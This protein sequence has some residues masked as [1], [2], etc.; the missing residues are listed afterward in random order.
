MKEK[1]FPVLLPTKDASN[2][3]KSVNGLRYLDTPMTTV[4]GWAFI[5]P[6]HLYLTSNREIRE[7]DWYYVKEDN[8]ILQANFKP[9]GEGIFKVEATTN[10]SLGLPTVS[11]ESLE[12][13]IKEQPKEVYVEMKEYNIVTVGSYGEY[14]RTPVL[15]PK[16]NSSN[17][18]SFTSVEQSW[19][20]IEKIYS[21]NFINEVSGVFSWLKQNY[22]VPKK[23][24]NEN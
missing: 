7:G 4:I 15:Y 11:K 2:I 18:I 9:V 22:S 8:V 6:Q 21:S 13:Y 20:D 16:T 19:E 5:E 12:L 14:L 10:K 1:M 17:E 23:L 3:F 24:N